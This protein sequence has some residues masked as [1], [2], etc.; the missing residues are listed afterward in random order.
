MRCSVDPPFDD[1]RS[2]QAA[3]NGDVIA[4]ERLLLART[5]EIAHQVAHRM[6]SYPLPHISVEDVLQEIYIDVFKGIGTFDL[7][8]G[9]SFSAWLRQVA[10]NRLNSIWRAHQ[11]QKRG[12]DRHCVLSTDNHFGVDNSQAAGQ[13]HETAAA[14]ASEQFARR[15]ITD[16]IRDRIAELPEEQRAAI[17]RHYLD[18]LS[19]S[20]TA[21]AMK[22]PSGAVRGL[23][24]RAKRSLRSAMG[25]SSR[26][27]YRK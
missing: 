12:G 5:D 24:H 18:E 16:A 20:S 21:D 19:V 8:K 13:I 27:F 23:L 17:E 7:A 15:E 3:I 9:G 14:T 2:V 10:D 6:K 4:L 11:R 22:K 26:W 1:D 25:Q